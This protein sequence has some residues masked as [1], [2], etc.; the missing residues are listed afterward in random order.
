MKTYMTNYLKYRPAWMQLLI[1]GSLIMGFYAVA[2]FIVFP[3]TAKIYGLPVMDFL[4][5][6]TNTPQGVSALKVRQVI[7]TIS[8]F[9]LPSALFAYLSDSNPF[10]YIGFK[11]PVPPSFFLVA[12]LVILVAFPMVAWLIEVN[13]HMHLPGSMQQVEKL[14][15]ELEAKENEM[16]KDL[17]AMKSI[18]DLMI[19]L[20]IVAVLPAI[21]EELFFRGVLQRLFIQLFKRPWTGIIVVAII[22]SA[23]HGQFLGFFPRFVLGVVL[24]ALY[25]YSGSLWPGIVAHFIYN[26]SQ[27]ILLYKSPQLLEKDPDFSAPL[28]VFSTVAVI[29]LIWRMHR[30]SQTTY[31]EVYDT[32]DF[33]IGP[34]DEYMQNK[35]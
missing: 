35:L 30:I 16:V 14:M 1:F 4:T 12:I 24:G 18:T 9:L 34:R 33:H 31:A 19:I 3:L 7:S 2:L 15:R 5:L 22:F 32:D 26:A 23:M 29:A 25:W 10:K 13:Q 28:I 11:K 8:L 17:L 21:A 27:V 20:T 6:D